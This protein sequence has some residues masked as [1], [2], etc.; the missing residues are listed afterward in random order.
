MKKILVSLVI[1]GAVGAL[2]FGASQAFFNDTETSKGNVLAAGAIDLKVD[3][4]CYYNGQACT[5]GHWGGNLNAPKCSGSWNSEDLTEENLFFDLHDIKPGDYE[6]DTISLTVHDNE[7]WLCAD[8]HLTSD[9]DVDCTDPEKADDANCGVPTPEPNGNNADGDLADQVRF[10]W[11]ADD[12]DNVLEDGERQLRGGPL[13]VLNVSQTANVALADSTT[14]VWSGLANDPIPL[15]GKTW[16]IGKAWCF[17]NITT[18]PLPQDG[19]GNVWSPAGNNDGNQTSGEPTDG[20]YKCDGSGVNNAA[21]TDM[22]T[23]DISFR[24]EQARHNDGF[25]CDER[26][27]PPG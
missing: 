26:A 8:V 17:G 16:Y 12:G 6:E 11:W 14:N 24:A 13:G 1:L 19:H 25:V 2:A 23:A 7:S 15:G 9:D 10:I 22:L 5:E 3:N 20:G 4:T 21:Q 27:R 18:A